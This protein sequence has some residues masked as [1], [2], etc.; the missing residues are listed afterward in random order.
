[1][2]FKALTASILVGASAL[3][4]GGTALAGDFN[5]T[6]GGYKVS[7]FTRNSSSPDYVAVAGPSGIA[8]MNIFCQRDGG[9]WWNAS[10]Y[11]T[12]SFHQYIANNYCETP[13]R[14]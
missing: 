11:N 14:Y 5:G 10:G 8:E 7:G 6:L 3:I 2:N 4:G 1:M 9:N 13:I 12:R